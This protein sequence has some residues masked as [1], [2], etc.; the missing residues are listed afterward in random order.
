MK[1]QAAGLKK[2]RDIQRQFATGIFRPLTA[3]YHM[4]PKWSDGRST[5]KAVAEFIKPNDRLTSYDRLEIYNKQ[6]WYRL[7]DCLYDDFPGLRSLMGN[8]RFHQMSIAYLDQHPSDSYTLRDLGNRL[9]KFLA[10]ETKWL[11]SNQK[12]GLELTRLEWA[13]IVAF[14]GD[15]QPPV[16]IDALLAGGDPAKLRLTFQPYLTFLKCEYPVDEYVLAVRR[17]EEPR[18]ETSNAVAE[19]LPQKKTKKIK[20]PKPRQT[21]LVIHRHD[22]SV[23]Y[24]HLTPEAYAIC[25]ALKKGLPLQVACERAFRRKA[26]DGNFA[27]TL[28]TYFAQW[29]AFGWFCRAE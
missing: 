12:F 4:R 29:A 1:S 11:A 18:G 3:G 28:Q 25:A 9:E 15:E 26:N 22:Q 13:H 6:Y 17:R 27:A 20:V 8:D 7:L 21:F 14:D 24:K 2:L 5:R 19:R 16:D 10:R 23:W